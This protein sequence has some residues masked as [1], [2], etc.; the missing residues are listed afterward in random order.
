M[1]HGDFIDLARRTQ[2]DNA[3]GG[4]AFNIAKNPKMMD[5]KEVFLPCFISL[6]I[7]KPLIVVFLCYKINN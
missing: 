6:L 1:A 7:K 3:L 5:I 2:S 4:K